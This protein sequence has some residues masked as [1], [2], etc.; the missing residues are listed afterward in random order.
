VPEGT[1]LRKFPVK[2]P[3]CSENRQSRARTLLRRQPASPVSP[4]C[5]T[6][7]PRYARQLRASC[8]SRCLRELPNRTNIPKFALKSLRNHWGIPVFWS[9][10]AETFKYATERGLAVR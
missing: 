7:K 6:E 10:D 8:L 9:R 4:K 1:G 3:V 5:T 2:F